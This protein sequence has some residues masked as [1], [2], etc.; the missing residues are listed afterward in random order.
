VKWVA[1]LFTLPQNLVY[2]ALLLLMRTPRLSAVDL[3]DAPANLN[4][5]ARFGQRQNLVSAH[6][7]SRFK[8]S[9]PQ[10]WT[11]SV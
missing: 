2:P 3:T 6:V 7:L 5:L 1:V 9:L 10:Q 8:R 11:A 4:G